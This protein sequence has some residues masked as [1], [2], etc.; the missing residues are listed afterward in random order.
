MR[1]TFAMLDDA[2]IERLFQ[3]AADLI[4]KQTGFTSTIAACLF[5][6]ASSLSWIVS[7]GLG[8]PDAIVSIDLG[9]A[10][11]DLVLLMLG[12]VAMICLRMLFQRMAAGHANP[13]RVAMQPH[14]AI[15]LL[16]LVAR[17]V[18]I[19]FADV[20]DAADV[21]MLI[22]TTTAL[23]L[24]ACMERPVLRRAAVSIAPIG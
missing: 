16:M 20:A 5:S 12:L 7:R 22:C 24:G 4:T 2:L 3:P 9:V 21:S 17:L 8:L 19:R 14:R 10:C 6:D 15:V 11:L 18:Q 13:L 23:Y 1:T